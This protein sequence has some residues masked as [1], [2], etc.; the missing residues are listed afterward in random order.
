[1]F[2]KKK[3]LTETFG[4]LVYNYDWHR[5]ITYELWGKTHTVTLS[6]ECPN[7][8]DS[9]LPIQGEAYN[10]F[11]RRLSEV[12]EKVTEYFLQN[13]YDLIEY[14]YLC[15]DASW[16]DTIE[17]RK[18]IQNIIDSY[19]RP[20]KDAIADMLSQ[21]AL[22]SVTIKR[23]GRVILELTVNVIDEHGLIVMIDSDI[24]VMIP[25][26]YD[27]YCIPDES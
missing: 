25:E 7:K 20:G 10:G 27:D 18:K 6:V 14:Y 4:K 16:G 5:D 3:I 19:D 11:L 15:C 13:Y 17:V 9:I 22:T 21:I 26:E 12:E 8:D 23:S 2:F 1:M 24:K